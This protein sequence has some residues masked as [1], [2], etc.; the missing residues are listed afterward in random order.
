MAASF[1]MDAM[2]GLLD[3]HTIICVV[4]MELR[5]SCETPNT[6]REEWMA[7]ENCSKLMSPSEE[8]L[9]FGKRREIRARTK[10]LLMG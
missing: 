5:V 3:A 2:E 9:G 10:R 4:K 7:F 1:C 8:S 6:A